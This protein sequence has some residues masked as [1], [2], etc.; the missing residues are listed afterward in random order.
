MS[1]LRHKLRNAKNYPLDIQILQMIF[2]MSFYGQFLPHIHKSETVA[3]NEDEKKIS[4]GCN[5]EEIKR[6]QE[7]CEDDMRRR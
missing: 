4:K 7:G 5:I 1:K 6:I 2:S 3:G